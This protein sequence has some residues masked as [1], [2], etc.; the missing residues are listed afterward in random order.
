MDDNVVNEQAKNL[1]KAIFQHESGMDYNATGD[2]GTSKGA[3]QW[4]PGTWK[5]QAKDVLGDE[6]APMTP[7]NQSVVAQGTIRGLIKKGKNAAQIA[8][9][10]NSGSDQGWENKV[11]T[12]T[13]NGQ[14]IKYNV[15]KYVKDVTD[16]YQQFKSSASP[17]VAEASGSQPTPEKPVDNRDFL[18]KASDVV[19][20]IFP[21]K[22]VGQAIGTLAGYIASPNK[23]T[24]DLSAPTPLQVAGD[25]AQ[26]ALTVG[27]GLGST[28][29]DAVKAFG[30]TV[31]VIKEA[32]SALG[33]IGQSGLLG[34]GIG[35]TNAIK[36]G[37]TDVKD[38]SKNALSGGLIGGLL[39][40]VGE[41]ISKL[42]QSI[43]RAMIH[44]KFED[45]SGPEAQKFLNQNIGTKESLLRQAQ[46][47]VR[48]EGN[49]ID[50]VLKS[51]PVAPSQTNPITETLTQFPEYAGKEA[52]LLQKIKSFV[53]NSSNIGEERKT[54]LEYVDKIANGQASLF[55]KNQV[56]KVLDLATKGGYA[57][58]AKS[59]APNAGHDL[60]M[61]FADS[62]RNEIQ[63][64]AKETVPMFQE[65]QKS[66]NIRKAVTKTVNKKGSGALLRYSD[67]LPFLSGNTMAGPIGGVTTIVGNRVIENPASRFATAKI[68]K[69]VLGGAGNIAKSKGILPSIIEK[70]KA[71][72]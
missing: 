3:G 42:A 66:L 31:S 36:E 15:P 71:P 14:Q 21:G 30:K 41:G 1:T 18:Q 40:G 33:R 61:T 72:K 11:G 17:N 68:T 2:A 10:W 51:Y 48:D 43:P 24:Y 59:I 4:Q 25:V 58:L 60:V 6:N 23:E 44:G 13:I 20:S 29:A 49:K 12:T 19:G 22:Q 35:A 56:R 62:L 26:G 7:E 9:I 34:A 52:K 28:G 5:A 45:L 27:A 37:N 32:G 65:L 46:N 39:G 67:L 69:N 50:A 70:R 47:V 55:E 57:K 53:S 16:L 8:A 54:I 64:T 63:N 38:I